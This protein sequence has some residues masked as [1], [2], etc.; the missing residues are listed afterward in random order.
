MPE[1]LRR[2]ARARS[3]SRPSP[4]RGPLPGVRDE[5]VAEARRRE[6]RCPP[7]YLRS[8][9]LPDQHG[10][11]LRASRRGEGDRL[12]VLHPLQRR[13]LDRKDRLQQR[14]LDRHPRL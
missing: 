9:G 5:E 10:F 13:R 4:N 8:M 6:R 2:D 14:L 12:E 11:R 3:S 7:R 1:S